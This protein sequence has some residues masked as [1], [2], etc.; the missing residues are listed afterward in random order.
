MVPLHNNVQ[1]HHL[2]VLVCW[3]VLDPMH[4]HGL[5]AM[6]FAKDHGTVYA[7]DH[8]KVCGTD[9]VTGYGTRNLVSCFLQM[10]GKK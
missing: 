1:N 2:T 7:R 5:H 9:R 8:G 10:N 4:H 6:V 3:V